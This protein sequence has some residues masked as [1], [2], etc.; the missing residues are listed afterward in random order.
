ME[1]FEDQIKKFGLIEKKTKQKKEIWIYSGGDSS[2]SFDFHKNLVKIGS[3]Y[4]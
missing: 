3:F 1:G 2:L 4:G